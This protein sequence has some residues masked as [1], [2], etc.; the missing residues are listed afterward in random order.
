MSNEYLPDQSATLNNKLI[1]Y[2]KYTTTLDYTFD[3]I[4]IQST[5]LKNK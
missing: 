2:S 3:K 5:F 1:K 4:F